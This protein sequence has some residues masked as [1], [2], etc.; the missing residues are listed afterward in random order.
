L[1][2]VSNFFGFQDFL[3][4]FEIKQTASSEVVDRGQLY[5]TAPS[6]QTAIWLVKSRLE[7]EHEGKHVDVIVH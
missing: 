3:V 4:N 1:S 7:K 6:R 5:Q 2:Q